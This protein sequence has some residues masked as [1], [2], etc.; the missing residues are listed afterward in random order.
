MLKLR[1]VQADR[2]VV[3]ISLQKQVAQSLFSKFR[4]D[5]GASLILSTVF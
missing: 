3:F 4:N 1:R 2:E 5:R